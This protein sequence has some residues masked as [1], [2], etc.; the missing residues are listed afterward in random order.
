MPSG[1][2]VGAIN[3]VAGVG[4]GAAFAA[5]QGADMLQPF[6]T[7][8]VPNENPSWMRRLGFTA[9]LSKQNIAGARGL[10]GVSFVRVLFADLRNSIRVPITLLAGALELVG[11]L[12]SIIFSTLIFAFILIVLLYFMQIY[13]RILIAFIIKVLTPFVNVAIE[14]ANFVI[15][16][17]ILVMRILFQIW[18]IFVPLLGMILYVVVDILVA[19][20]RAVF[21]IL[22]SIDIM[23]IISTYLEF[24]FI[25][26]DIYLQVIMVFLEV[27]MAIMQIM[28]EVI[29][30]VVEMIMYAISLWVDILFWILDYLFRILEPI[31][32]AV[33]A[34]VAAFTWMLNAKSSMNFSSRK[35]LSL[36]VAATLTAGGTLPMADQPLAETTDAMAPP[37]NYDDFL[38]STYRQWREHVA[39]L[40]GT[41]AARLLQDNYN[42]GVLQPE[43]SEA[44]LQRDIERRRNAGMQHFNLGRQLFGAAD[45]PQP[46]F[47]GTTRVP[48]EAVDR[49]T[50]TFMHHFHTGVH[51]LARERT[52][53]D[54]M[55]ESMARIRAHW[56]G[57]DHLSMQS[58]MRRFNE[59]HP[60]LAKMPHGPG[61]VRYT[62]DPEHPRD[63]HVRLH[64]ERQQYKQK[65]GLPPAFAVNV[66]KHSQAGGGGRKLL[67]TEH[68]STAHWD[69]S[70]RVHAEHLDRM[71]RRHAREI[72]EQERK[73][74]D[75]HHTR[76]KTARVIHHSLRRTLHKH[77]ST[78]LHPDTLAHHGSRFL[79]RFGYDSAWDAYHH[80]L[81]THSD[82][83]SFVISLSSF[84]EHPLMQFWAEKD[85]RRDTHRFFH[86]WAREQKLID[87]ARSSAH[88]FGTGRKLL[89]AA[90]ASD[91]G[92]QAAGNSKESLSGFEIVSKTDCFSDPRNPLCMPE[93]GPE[94]KVEISTVAWPDD[95]TEDADICAPWI[96]TLCVFC[97]AR[98]LNALH[99]VRFVISGFPPFNFALTAL[100]VLLPWMAWAI[101]WVFLVGKREIAT[102]RQ[103]LCF[104]IHIY[105]VLI[106]AVVV[107]FVWRFV[108]PLVRRLYLFGAACCSSY[109]AYKYSQESAWESE[110]DN[111]P[112]FE[113][114][115]RASLLYARA[116]S[117]TGGG[118]GGGI[119]G[120]GGGGG[121][122]GNSFN[123]T[124]FNL[125]GMG[126]PIKQRL[127]GDELQQPGESATDAFV[128]HMSIAAGAQVEHQIAERRAHQLFRRMDVDLDLDSS[129]HHPLNDTEQQ[130]AIAAIQEHG[131][132]L[133]GA[134]HSGV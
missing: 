121:G 73:F 12:L 126:P 134:A 5:S 119:G 38:S 101:D 123:N 39:T 115:A 110:V 28:V 81:E 21:E 58:V 34:L 75:Y 127:L 16:L 113:K 10:E 95:I 27:G 66:G 63:T 112:A 84:M 97:P 118:G 42:L 114:A 24:N 100:T 36:G 98:M 45:K 69:D 51:K 86:D 120:G 47:G 2:V 128:R 19:V 53:F 9:R 4:Q 29:S 85:E 30:F 83:E 133:E 122:G 46:K 77:A 14:V 74:V 3:V 76:V 56:R 132:L 106:T 107:W 96:T 26:I 33:Q 61:H 54:S 89:Q 23:P 11:E 59:Q 91:T 105:D 50:H 93:I 68:V 37:P 65:H 64:G 48:T 130:H 41:E 124:T 92:A 7:P 6:T 102:L 52:D 108:W 60:T 99:M 71:Q 40:N 67:S 116:Q 94:F 22:G 57:T 87:K 20:F 25:I 13:W 8:V 18:N 90:S 62:Q 44:A 43:H 49:T 79:E 109:T 17:N 111:D 32:F 103:V 125:F 82:A 70:E 1:A 88:Q 35:L 55:H 129:S 72:V 15:A 131:H 78:T 31:L 117:S 80:F 104:F